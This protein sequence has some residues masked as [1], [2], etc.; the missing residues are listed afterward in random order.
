MNSDIQLRKI[1]AMEAQCNDALQ[2]NP[3]SPFWLTVS[4]LISEMK[5]N[6]DVTSQIEFSRAEAKNET[7]NL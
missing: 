5:I 7:T 4:D 6:L 3:E 2:N 1:G